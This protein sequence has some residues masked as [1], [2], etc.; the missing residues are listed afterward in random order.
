MRDESDSSL[1]L[2][3]GVMRNVELLEKTM[4]HIMD[5]PETHNQR[6]WVNGCG[7][8]GC[9]AGWA[10]LLSPE[11]TLEELYFTFPDGSQSHT[12]DAAMRVLGLTYKEADNL[13]SEDNSRAMLQLIFKDLVNG[14]SLRT[15]EQYRDEAA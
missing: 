3:G 12:Q 2:I 15:R 14:D 1:Y 6:M 13:F 7:T 8:V 11:I 9:F 4:Q 10:C 5:H